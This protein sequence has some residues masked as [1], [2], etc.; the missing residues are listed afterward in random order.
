MVMLS[1]NVYF[2]SESYSVCF[3]DHEQIICR[4]LLLALCADVVKSDVFD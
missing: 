3:S 1:V 2:I 4:I